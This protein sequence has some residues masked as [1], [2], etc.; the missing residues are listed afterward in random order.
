[1]GGV[2][3]LVVAYYRVDLRH[4]GE[5][6]RLGL[7]GAA[8]DHDPC[9]WPFAA[10]AADGLACLTYRF[11]GYR[12]AVDD[13]QVILPIRHFADRL[14]LRDVEAAAEGDDLR[15]AHALK[16]GPVGL[17]IEDVGGGAGHQDVP[18]G[19]PIDDEVA[20]GQGHA[21]GAADELAPH[22]CD[23]CCAGAGAARPGEASAALPHDKA[24]MIVADDLRE[25]HI[26][27]GWEER[28]GLDQRA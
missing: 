12:A 5:G 1:M 17:A 9:L 26:D 22:G 13:D 20:A 28:I 11:G 6:F 23:G 19:L 21:G 24:D 4:F 16:A 14:A 8:R 15:A 27:A 18:A 2:E 7:C 25:V 3:F 10:G